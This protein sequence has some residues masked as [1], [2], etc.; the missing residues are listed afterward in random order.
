M[1]SVIVAVNNL[2][3]HATA[4]DGLACTEVCDSR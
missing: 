4:N 3:T 1:E 2:E